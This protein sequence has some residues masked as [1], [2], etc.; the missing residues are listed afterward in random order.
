MVIVMPRPPPDPVVMTLTTRMPASFVAIDRRCTRTSHI[1]L[2]EAH[3]SPYGGVVA[4]VSPEPPQQ[5]KPHAL[6]LGARLLAQTRS[7]HT[8]HRHSV[9]VT[10]AQKLTE[11]AFSCLHGRSGRICRWRSANNI[12]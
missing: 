1:P 3:I 7:S 6:S 11:N 10:I 8:Q 5:S 4:A 12:L 2:T 9:I